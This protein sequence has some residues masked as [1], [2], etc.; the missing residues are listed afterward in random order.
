MKN[1]K[2]IYQ[3][4]IPKLKIFKN[5]FFRFGYSRAISKGSLKLLKRN[6]VS[7]FAG[8]PPFPLETL[9]PL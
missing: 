2:E 1:E 7:V 5:I 8:C 9:L 3:I 4:F 6:S